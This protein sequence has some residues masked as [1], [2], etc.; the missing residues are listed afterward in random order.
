ME[1]LVQALPRTNLIMLEL[2]ND[3]DDQKLITFLFIE[4]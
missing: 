4:K 1:L 3:D 2:K